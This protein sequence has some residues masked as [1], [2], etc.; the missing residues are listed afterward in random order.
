MQQNHRDYQSKL[1]LLQVSYL[2]GIYIMPVIELVASITGTT[3]ITVSHNC[4]LNIC[5]TGTTVT[6]SS[7]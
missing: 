7:G 1:L 2:S 4:G 5:S 6:F 3:V